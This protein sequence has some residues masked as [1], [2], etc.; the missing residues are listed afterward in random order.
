MKQGL[1][2]AFIALI[3]DQASKIATLAYFANHVPPVKVTSF[4]NYVLA[5]NRGVSFSMFHSDKPLAPV[6]L[7]VVALMICGI[8]F[9]WMKNEKDVKTQICFGLILG[10]AIGNIVD[11]IRFG[12][13][14]DF[15]DFYVGTHH[16]P[17]FNIADSAICVGAGYILLWNLFFAPIEKPKGSDK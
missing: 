16:W 15:L 9:Y 13:V 17:A 4:F 8:V 10:G 14:V 6:V 11:R 3:A 1:I 5:W 12:A 2:A 7:T